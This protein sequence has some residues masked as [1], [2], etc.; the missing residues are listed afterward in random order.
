MAVSHVNASENASETVFG[1]TT[2]PRTAGPVTRRSRALVVLVV[3]LGVGSSAAGTAQ[4]RLREE[5]IDFLELDALKESPRVAEALESP[6]ALLA[7]LGSPDTPFL[8]RM[9][10]AHTASSSYPITA[11]PAL[12]SA[13]GELRETAKRTNFWQVGAHPLS[14]AA[15]FEP[16]VLERDVVVLGHHFEVPTDEIPYPMTLAEKALAP[17]PWQAQRALDHLER[18]L[19]LPSPATD[20]DTGDESQE[21]RTRD[22]LEITLRLPCA[23]VNEA[24]LVSQRAA[25]VAHEHPLPNLSLLGNLALNPTLESPTWAG[26]LIHHCRFRPSSTPGED[27]RHHQACSALALE[28][29]T[30]AVPSSTR[31]AI[32]SGVGYL[33][34]LHP[35]VALRAARILRDDLAISRLQRAWYFES[36]RAGHQGR[37]PTVPSGPTSP[38]D[39]SGILEEYSEWFARVAPELERQVESDSLPSSSTLLPDVKQCAAED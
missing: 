22:W 10:A 32:L 34:P 19:L 36:L 1:E 9:I 31:D 38:E 7:L 28:L 35:A 5:L 23:T 14:A 24:L 18:R 33:Q 3:L 4:T 39:V 29:L 12:W 15:R 2:S 17:W 6:T 21:T 25:R 30:D 27:S 20:R 11:V 13:I 16:G 8:E 26:S 37:E